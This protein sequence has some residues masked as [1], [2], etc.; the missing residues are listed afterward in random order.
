[1]PRSPL[2]RR[3]CPHCGA[4]FVPTT[5]HHIYCSLRCGWHRRNAQRGV[6]HQRQL[7]VC[8]ACGR[9]FTSRYD[10]RFCSPACGWGEASPHAK[11]T[12]DDVRD[13]RARYATGTVSMRKLAYEFNVSN[14]VIFAI[15]NRRMWKHVE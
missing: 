4:D 6:A 14:P 9:P 5:A 13:I 10:S 11:L 7:R 2:P 12:E 15:V 3:T 8:D 1:M